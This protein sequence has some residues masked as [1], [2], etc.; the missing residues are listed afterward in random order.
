MSLSSISPIAQAFPNTPV[1]GQRRLLDTGLDRSFEAGDILVRQG[2]DA[3]LVLVLDGYLG[4]R[5]TTDD[6]RE[7]VVRIIRAG[8]LAAIMVIASRPAIFDIV[9]ITRCRAALWPAREIRSLASVEAGFAIDLLDHVL[10]TFETVVEGL[11]GFIYQDAVKR[12]SRILHL[13]RELFFGE[14]PVLTR[15]HLPM[16]VGTSRE[17]TGRVLRRLRADGVVAPTGR[18][19]L[20]ILDPLRLEEIAREQPRPRGTGGTSSSS[21]GRA[22]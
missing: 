12:V 5:R 14:Q 10:H 13:H 21:H 2:E 3:R 20:R 4:L 22:E 7:L 6:G 16:L 19:G 1:A 8:G 17:M 15:S 11:D 9:A 18:N